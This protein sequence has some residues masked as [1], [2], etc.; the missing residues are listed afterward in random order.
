LTTEKKK[1]KPREFNSNFKKDFE[2]FFDTFDF[3]KYSQKISE[4]ILDKN[5]NSVDLYCEK[6]AFFGN[7]FDRDLNEY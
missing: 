7:E 5:F 4:N 2:N 6:E 3:R 1:L